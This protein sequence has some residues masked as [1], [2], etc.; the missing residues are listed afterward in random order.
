MW[1]G[2]P[3]RLAA[4]GLAVRPVAVAATSARFALICGQ[5]VKWQG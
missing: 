1:F 3:L 2:T 5:F 4:Q